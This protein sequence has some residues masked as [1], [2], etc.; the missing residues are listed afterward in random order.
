[1]TFKVQG[2]L[3]FA[4]LLTATPALAQTAAPVTASG[5]AD[6]VPI[7]PPPPGK[8]QV[9]FFRHL[10]LLGAVYWA[11]VREHDVELGKLDDGVYFVQTV[12][13]GDH[14]Y[15]VSLMGKDTL[16]LEVDPGETYYVEGRMTMALVGYSMILAP[17]D[18]ASF[19]KAAGSMSL[20]KPPVDDKPPVSATQ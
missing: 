20:A 9:V 19:Q 2:A 18:A 5:P 16:R 17:S 6:T 15:S 3:V 12:E 11:K 8:G 13:P 7:A 10:G 4:A 14:A 1:M